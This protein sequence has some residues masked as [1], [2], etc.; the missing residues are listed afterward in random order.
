MRYMMFFQW[1]KN[2]TGI[3]CRPHLG[4]TGGDS[5]YALGAAV[6]PLA[7]A[8]DQGVVS[9]GAVDKPLI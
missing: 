8:G 5:S 9:T 7:A 3:A 4:Q 1:L 2:R 6:F